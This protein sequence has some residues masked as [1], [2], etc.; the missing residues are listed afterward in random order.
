MNKKP[1][2]QIR[3]PLVSVHWV[4]DFSSWILVEFVFKEGIFDL[5]CAQELPVVLVWTSGLPHV[6]WE[7][8]IQ[9][10]GKSQTQ[11]PV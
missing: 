6:S 10:K 4:L 1:A 5:W 8:L 3:R 9:W 2:L 7:T 11:D